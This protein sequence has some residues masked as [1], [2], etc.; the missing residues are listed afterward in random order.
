MHCAIIMWSCHP[1]KHH[2]SQ[3]YHKITNMS[4][5]SSLHF[6]GFQTLFVCLC[7]VHTFN[8]FIATTYPLSYGSKLINSKI[9]LGSLVITIS[10]WALCIFLHWSIIGAYRTLSKFLNDLMNIFIFY[11]YTLFRVALRLLLLFRE[12]IASHKLGGLQ[13]TKLCTL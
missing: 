2:Q 11:T 7:C 8:T 10:H 1:I 13:Q 9:D 3:H 4:I 5:L 12:K 6:I